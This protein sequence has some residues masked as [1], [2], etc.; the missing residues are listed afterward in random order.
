M[1]QLEQDPAFARFLGAT[2]GED[3]HGTDVTVLSM[4]ARLDVDPWIEASKLASM[5]EETA[6]KRLDTLMARFKDVPDLISGRNTIIS[7][8]LGFLPRK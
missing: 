6:R 4:L 2:V 3:N 5:P 8:L 1:A 7:T